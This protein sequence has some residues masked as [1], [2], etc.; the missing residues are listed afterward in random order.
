MSFWNRLRGGVDI[1]QFSNGTY[2]AH[3]GVGLGEHFLGTD[4]DRWSVPEFVRKYCEV[5]TI[6]E[7]RKLADTY[8]YKRGPV[9]Y[10]EVLE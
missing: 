2:G 5:P 8:V 1:V 4:G 3:I 7:A 10:K 6:E 9:K